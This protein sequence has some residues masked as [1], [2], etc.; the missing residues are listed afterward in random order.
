MSKIGKKPI[1]IPEGVEVKIDDGI[2]KIKGKR[3]EL[4]LLILPFIK[5]DLNE[6]AISLS[7]EGDFKQARA[8]W[9][10]MRALANNA[11]IG[12]SDGFSKALEIGGVGYRASLEGN[13]LVLNIGFTNPVKI[14]PPEGI[15]ISVEKNVIKVSG[16]DKALV[17]KTAAEIR[18]KKKPEPYKGKGIKY[19][20]EI[21]RRKE[22]KK[23]AAAAK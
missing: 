18:A 2:L 19:Q 23:A 4:S 3:G 5:I 9:G 13:N 17:G 6:Q 1:I 16:N 12:V 11:V 22:G 14:I 7:A 20:G 8:N 21:I 15:I 10:T